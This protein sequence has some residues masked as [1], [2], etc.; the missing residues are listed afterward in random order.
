MAIPA[1]TL[2]RPP[3]TTVKPE[4]RGP[5]TAVVVGVNGLETPGGADICTDQYG[6]VRVKFPWDRS[7]DHDSD[8]QTSAWIRV[9]ENWA[10]SEWGFQF[11]PRVGH[12]VVVQFVD[13]DPDRPL[14]TGRIYNGTFRQPF[15]PPP[16][17]PPG[18]LQPQ[19]SHV[20]TTQR[21]SGIKTQST[22]KPDGGRVRFHSLR[23]DD[24]YRTEQIVLRCQHRLDVTAFQNAYHTTH[25]NRHI[26]VGG[27]DPDTGEGGVSSYHQE[28]GGDIIWEVGS[29]YFGCRTAD[30]HF[31]PAKFAEVVVLL[32]DAASDSKIGDLQSNTLVHG[33]IRLEQD[34]PTFGLKRRRLTVVK[35]RG[36]Y[37]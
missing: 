9:A 32:L 17:P 7:T 26:L 36:V 12:E 14:I 20:Q 18:P 11:P 22:P 8:G 2:F 1:D 19:N 5:H 16:L 4:I 15:V 37:A 27:K 10:G 33:V 6:R 31:D 24:T 30:G 35:L 29:G 25:G 3:R 34:L 13:G 28:N 23:F 21:L